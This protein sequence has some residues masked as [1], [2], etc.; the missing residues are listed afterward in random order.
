PSQLGRTVGMTMLAYL[1]VVRPA[2]HPESVRSLFL[3]H[4]NVVVAFL[5]TM[6]LSGSALSALAIIVVFV[7][8]RSFRLATLTFVLIFFVWPIVLTIDYEPLQRSVLLLS[9][10]PT[11]DTGKIFEADGSGASRLIPTLI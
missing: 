4:R 2:G 8:S 11:L 6:L 10:L 9:S 7:M 3:K 1:I 5:V